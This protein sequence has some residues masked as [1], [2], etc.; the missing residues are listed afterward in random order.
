MIGAAT[1]IGTFCCTVAANVRARPSRYTKQNL[2]NAEPVM[3]NRILATC[4]TVQKVVVPPLLSLRERQV[5][6]CRLNLDADVALSIAT[7][8]RASSLANQL[9]RLIEKS[10]SPELLASANKAIA[11]WNLECAD[12]FFSQRR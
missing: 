3:S 10:G 5:F 9:T 8:D 2:I 12:A 7:Q 6:L 11:Q 4:F 1:A